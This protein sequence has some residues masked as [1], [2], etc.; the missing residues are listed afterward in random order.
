[1]CYYEIKVIYIYIYIY[2]YLHI[3]IYIYI[4]IYITSGHR[5]CISV[6]RNLLR[7][8]SRRRL[9]SHPGVRS[10]R[11]HRHPLLGLLLDQRR[12]VAGARVHRRPHRPDDDDP[13][14]ERQYLATACIL[15]QGDRRLDVHVPPLRLRRDARVRRCQRTVEEEGHQGRPDVVVVVVGVRRRRR[16][17]GRAGKAAAPSADRPSST[18]SSAG[19]YRTGREILH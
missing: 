11:A 4:Y 19:S 14:D 13:V 5:R 1:M 17:V 6:P 18:R 12:R 8:S 3:Y 15:H 7:P 16:R 2:I 9:L 10:E